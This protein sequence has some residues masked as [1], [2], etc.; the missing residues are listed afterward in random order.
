MNDRGWV[1]YRHPQTGRWHTR[2][3]AMA[4]VETGAN[5]GHATA[6]GSEASS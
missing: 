3:E 2:A 5:S 6:N 4:I 1:I